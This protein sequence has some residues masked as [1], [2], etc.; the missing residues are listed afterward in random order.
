M[1]SFRS[2]STLGFALAASLAVPAF[3]AA[4]AGA[5]PFFNLF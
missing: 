3:G 1:L 5:L 4:G 2:I